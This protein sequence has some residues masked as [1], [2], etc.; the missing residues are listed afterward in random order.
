[1]TAKTKSRPRKAAV[2]VVSPNTEY[3]DFHGVNELFGLR[4][5]TAYHLVNEGVIRSVSLKGPNEK[6]GKRLF[7]VQSIREFLRSRMDGAAST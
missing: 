2:T 4:R 1:M 3:T 5:S 6:R 7:D